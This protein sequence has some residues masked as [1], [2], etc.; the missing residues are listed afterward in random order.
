MYNVM[1]T[2]RGCR[3]VKFNSCNN[4]LSSVHTM[5]VIVLQYVR[6]NIKMKILLLWFMVVIEIVHS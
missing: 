6:L 3:A 4:L 2:L 5:L 1:D